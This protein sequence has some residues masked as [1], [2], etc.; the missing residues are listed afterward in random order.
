MTPQ[1]LSGKSLVL[2][3]GGDRLGHCFPAAG[4]SEEGFRREIQRRVDD[5][6]EN[7]RNW[8]TWTTLRKHWT[9]TISMFLCL[10]LDR[11]PAPSPVTSIQAKDITRHT[12]SLAWQ[13][14]DRANGVILEYEVKYYEKVRFAV[15]LMK[16]L[17]F[18]TLRVSHLS[19]LSFS[20]QGP[21]WKKLQNHKNFIQ[22]HRHQR[23]HPSY[24]L[25]VPRARSHGS[26][27][28]G[29]QRPVWG[30]DQLWW[31]LLC[32]EVSSAHCRGVRASMPAALSRLYLKQVL[33]WRRLYELVSVTM[34]PLI[35]MTVVNKKTNDT[36][37]QLL[38][39]N[40]SCF[41]NSTCIEWR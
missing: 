31:V 38:T 26:W 14:P 36:V 11:S 10:F 15:L 24:F 17:C 16:I 22:D 18:S 12:I 33:Q 34:G 4:A 30:H 5:S 19:H 35:K 28:R 27:L 13:P 20:S 8:R 39:G 40:M 1:I 23:P 32:R 29:V 7:W 3:N 6:L 25:R 9:K 2:E 41:H 21:K 37:L